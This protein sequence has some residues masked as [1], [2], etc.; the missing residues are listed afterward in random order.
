MLFITQEEEL[1]FD[2]PFQSLYFYAQWMPFHKKML[3]M[4]SKVEEKHKDVSF[5]AIDVD[6]FK[7]L[8]KRFNISSIPTVLILNSGME[9]K[10][11]NGIVMTSAFKSAFSD[12][13]KL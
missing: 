3:T 8:C 9:A 11:I 13:C 6:H 7:G 10:R 4:I 2:K 1:K 5:F 12:I